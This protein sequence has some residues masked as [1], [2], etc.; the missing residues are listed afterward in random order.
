VLPA[1]VDSRE[2]GTVGIENV[3]SKM[4]SGSR[5][6]AEGCLAGSNDP[7]YRSER[8]MCSPQ[9]AP[10]QLPGRTGLKL[11]ADGKKSKDI[12]DWSSVYRCEQ[13]AV[14]IYTTS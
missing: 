4:M 5:F 2:T 10:L 9:L 14:V 6:A 8:I 1:L 11:T 7:G 13:S 3:R 12:S